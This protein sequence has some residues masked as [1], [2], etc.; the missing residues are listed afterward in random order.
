MLRYDL[1]LFLLCALVTVCYGSIIKFSHVGIVLMIF[2]TLRH[3]KIFTLL[4]D[5][6]IL[7]CVR[8]SS[9]L[10]DVVQNRLIVLIRPRVPL[11]QTGC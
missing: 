9:Q 8:N 10:C 4:G 6:F 3:I 7:S 1:P 11:A 2:R 5:Q